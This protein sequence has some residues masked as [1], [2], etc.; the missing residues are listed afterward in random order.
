MDVYHKRKK[1][2]LLSYICK[3]AIRYDRITEKSAHS[4]EDERFFPSLS[5]SIK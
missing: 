2:V 5:L 4:P 1:L 3:D